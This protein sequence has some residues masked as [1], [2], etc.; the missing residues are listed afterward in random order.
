VM[1]RVGTENAKFIK[2]YFP[3]STSQIPDDLSFCLAHI[4]CDLYQPMVHALEYFYPRMQPGGF[5]IIH[6][7]GS[8]GW[9]GAEQAVDEFFADKP[10]A[11]IPLPDVH[12]SAIIRKVRP[13][14]DRYNWLLNKRCRLF[15]DE[16]VSAG[17]GGI[18]PLL[19]DGWS[20]A[21]QWGVWGIG[22]RHILNLYIDTEVGGLVRL[23]TK[24]SAALLGERETQEVDVVL[25]DQIVTT[26]KFTKQDNLAIRTVD[27]PVQMAKHDKVGITQFCVEFRPRDFRSPQ[28]LSA[29]SKDDRP[30]GM[31][32]RA[33]RC[34]THKSII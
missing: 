6:D 14:G 29:P 22:P 10:E 25:D 13:T 4:D 19:G 1:A 23:E 33:I 28:Q 5:L 30:L 7:Y 9:D 12:G 11:V 26:W 34:G 15:M 8:L 21:E 2:G 17:S 24:A 32:L 31:S 3:E 20:G 27:L 16:W 18:S